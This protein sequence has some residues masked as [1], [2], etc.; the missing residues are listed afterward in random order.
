MTADDAIEVIASGDHVFVG[1]ACGTPT[2]LL[3]ALEADPWTR[4]GV[5]LVHFLLSGD[6]PDVYDTPS[7][8]YRQRVWF[9]GTGLRDL[10]GAGR[11][12]YVPISLAEVPTMMA[13]GRL[14]IDV[15]IIQVG[16]PDEQGQCSLGVSVD[17]V[18]AAVEHAETVVAE[19][20]PAMPRT[21]PESLIAFDRLDRIVEVDRPV[22]EYVH[23]PVGDVGERIA[24]YIAR[25]V[26]DGD[27]LQIGLGRVPNTM[28]TYLTNR[29]DLGVHSDVITEPLV[30]LLD[31][32]VV[33]G[34]RKN[35]DRGSVV[36]S[37][38]MG[39]ERLY[40]RIDSNDGIEL[41]PIERVCSHSVLARHEQLVSVTQ[42]FAVDLT[43]QVCADEFG[44]QLYGGVATQPDFHRSAARSPGGKAIVCVASTTEN[45]ESRIEPRL[46]TGEG[47]AIPRSEVHYVVTE[48]GIA[49]LFGRS[50]AERA[51][52]LIEIAHP[53]HRDE[54]L[55]EAKQLGLVPDDQVLRSRDAYPIDAERN[56]QLADGSE[57]L[58]RPTRTTDTGALQDLFYALPPEDVYTRFFRN[59]DSLSDKMAQHLCSVDYEH[60]MAFAAVS[61][62]DFEG[63]RIVG[64]SAYYLDPSTN[65]AD[66]AYMVHPDWQGLGLGTALQQRT[67]TYAQEQGIRG[68]TADVLTENDAMLHVLNKAPGQVETRTHDGIH[69]LKMLFEG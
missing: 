28:L 40:S 57:V 61:G 65:L 25:L 10:V 34:T 9:V 42:A 14:P 47:V 24:R 27:T 48:Y 22:T 45:G 51:V 56:V 11:A 63:G 29:R 30:E 32:G 68:F 13:D 16:P 64:S 62:E 6:V 49:Y 37:M 43:G 17:V 54:L 20:A 35:V 18:H 15:A 46:R 36:A 12:E 31:A 33:T 58:I 67:V 5:E 21:G 4:R 41:R 52:A 44:G 3:G 1:G 69:E 60:E 19:V 23:E 53:D 59:L 26:D 2:T 39:T 55:E 66:V 38:A 8:G 7:S 50:L